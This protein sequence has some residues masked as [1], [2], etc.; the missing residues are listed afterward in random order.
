[1]PAA[2]ERFAQLCFRASRP[3]FASRRPLAPP[4]G[5]QLAPP[6]S[7][8]PKELLK[9]DLPRRTNFRGRS[10]EGGRPGRVSRAVSAGGTDLDPGWCPRAG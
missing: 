10:P 2:L 8:V 4:H 3:C 9:K 5:L 7:R 6:M 1:M